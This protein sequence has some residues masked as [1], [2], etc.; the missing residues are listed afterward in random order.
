MPAR[1]P[2]IVRLLRTS[3]RCYR[4]KPGRPAL[5]SGGIALGV[6][7]I[8]ALDIINGSVISNFRTMLERTA[9][10]AA[11]Q[12]ELGTGEVGFDEALVDPVAADPDVAHAFAMVRGTL[13]ASDGS[14]EVLQLF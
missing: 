8:A 6:S 3:W 7:L 1:V 5:M 10:K 14:G 4:A 12:V 2:T 11:L 9:G 13:H